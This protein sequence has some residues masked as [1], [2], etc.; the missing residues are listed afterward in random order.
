MVIFASFLFFCSTGL[1]FGGASWRHRNVV[2][3]AGLASVA[4][5][6]V[7]YLGSGSTSASIYQKLADFVLPYSFF[8]S[9]AVFF[10]RRVRTRPVA[11]AIAGLIAV[12][13]AALAYP[14]MY[15]S[16]DWLY[17]RPTSDIS[18]LAQP[19]FSGARSGL[20]WIMS[21]G[22]SA[23]DSLLSDETVLNAVAATT[24]TFLFAMAG[25]ASRLFVLVQRTALD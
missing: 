3:L 22:S 9:S 1:F 19:L 15:R 23:R 17:Q 10:G 2:V 18:G 11:V 6:I 13:F 25:L 5:A 4:L 7:L 24:M 16:I 21:T 20:S 8:V 14:E 12:G